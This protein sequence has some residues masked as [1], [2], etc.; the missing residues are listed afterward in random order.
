[1]DQ[2]RGGGRSDLAP[3][4]VKFFCVAT[5]VLME[6]LCNLVTFPKIYLRRFSKNFFLV[7][8]DCVVNSVLSIKTL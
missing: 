7:T 8:M 6:G 3:P 5:E 4:P 2:G 1:M